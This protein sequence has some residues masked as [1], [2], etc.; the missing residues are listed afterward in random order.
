M[1]QFTKQQAEATIVAFHIGRGGQF[2]N[3]GYLSFIGEYTIGHYVDDDL[4]LSR[5]NAWEIGKKIKGKKN[6]EAKFRSALEGDDDSVS[7]FEKIGLSLGE[8]IYIDCNGNSVGLTQAEEETGIGRIN[9]DHDYNTTYTCLL[10]DIDEKEAQAVLRCK[11]Y[12]NSEIIDYAKELLG[13]A[14]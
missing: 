6:L 9:I 10:K 11:E 1:K 4:F 7:F 2:R 8:L 5:E 3:P 12:I 13:I 14:Q